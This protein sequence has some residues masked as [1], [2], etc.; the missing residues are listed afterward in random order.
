MTEKYLK[1]LLQQGE[2]QR[3]EFKPSLS[4]GKRLVEIIASFANSSGGH[5]IIFDIFVNTGCCGFS[6]LK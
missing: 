6:G 4:Q 5:L 2:S 1:Q 3:M